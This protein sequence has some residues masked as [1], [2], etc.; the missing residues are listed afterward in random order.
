MMTVEMWVYVGV[1]HMRHV[2]YQLRHFSSKVVFFK[3]VV[4]VLMFLFLLYSLV[5]LGG[6]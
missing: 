2:V 1:V 5:P 4:M 3:M 6:D